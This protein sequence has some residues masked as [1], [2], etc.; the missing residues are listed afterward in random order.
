MIR[1]AV[2]DDDRNVVES[3][4]RYLEEKNDQLQEERLSISPY[5]SGE[6]F[7]RD[8]ELGTSFHIVFMD[9]EMDDIDGVET[10]HALR[11]RPNGD[12]TIMI[13]ISSH[14]SYYE[15]I[16]QVGFYRF[17][18]KPISENKLDHVFSKALSQAIRYKS[19]INRP[20]LFQYKINTETYS[21]RVDEIAYV[22]SNKKVVELYI[23]DQVKKTVCFRDSFYS[24]IAEVLEQLPKE[25]FVQC[26]RSHIV[27]L[28]YVCQARNDSLTL[29]DKAQTRITMGRAYKESTKER[30]FKRRRNK[31]A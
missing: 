16:A 13:Y 3:I 19:A 22:K 10:G 17:I 20:R 8:I 30:Y 7:L 5:S 18:K 2:C 25:E 23:L 12:D 27:N 1:I 14:D 11:N 24:S 28:D 9:I 26:S 21:V 31:Y 29:I 4:Q 15:R 6:D